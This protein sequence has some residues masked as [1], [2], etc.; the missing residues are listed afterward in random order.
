MSDAKI[1]CT[2]YRDFA[3]NEIYALH[4]MTITLS[5][6]I[7]TASVAILAVSDQPTTQW[8][9]KVNIFFLFMVGITGFIN[10]FITWWWLK[11]SLYDYYNKKDDYNDL[12]TK[13]KV[14]CVKIGV[15]S[16]KWERRIRRTFLV[17]SIFFI[18]FLFTRFIN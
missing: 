15:D 14:L 2:K 9:F 10:I 16:K 7:I 17:C 4:R 5:T 1:K 12:P 18:L 6:F 13:E 11:T 3:R 8:T